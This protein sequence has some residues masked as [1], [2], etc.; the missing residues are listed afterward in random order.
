MNAPTISHRNK[1]SIEKKSLD[2]KTVISQ[3]IR[4]GFVGGVSAILE[5]A[6]FQSLC[7]FTNVGI[8]QSN[9]IAV[10]ASTAVNFAM[11]RSVTFRST[12]N[13]AKSLVLYL[14]LFLFNTTFSTLTITWL[15]S[16]GLYPFIAKILTMACVIMW[17]FVLYRKFIFK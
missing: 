7:I 10:L 4:Y 17:N 16:L 13:P 6:L 11:N 2:L 9:I 15:T 3:F 12:S 14:M 8:A 5:L 1:P